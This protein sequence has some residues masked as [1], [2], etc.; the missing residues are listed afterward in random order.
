MIMNRSNGP[1]DRIK[2]FQLLF[3]FSFLLPTSFPPSHW[4]ILFDSIEA[5]LQIYRKITEQRH[6]TQTIMFTDS[7]WLYIFLICWQWFL[8][9]TNKWENNSNG[10]II[11]HLICN[12]YFLF[13]FFCIFNIFFG[14]NSMQVAKRPDKSTPHEAKVRGN[15]NVSALI[16]P[17]YG[18]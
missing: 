6:R 13:E 5:A 4:G 8:S 17:H 14:K 10:W 12:V 1:V 9:V 11:T 3:F 15:T 18:R 16:K 2:P 7:V